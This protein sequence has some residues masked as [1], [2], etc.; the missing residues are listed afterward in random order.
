MGGNQSH[1]SAI[2]CLLLGEWG[3]AKTTGDIVVS[4][5][6]DLKGG[7]TQVANIANGYETQSKCRAWTT[8][9]NG[10]ETQ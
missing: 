6:G 9:T 2:C 3:V 5:F 10:Y 8:L 4:T 1:I 7:R